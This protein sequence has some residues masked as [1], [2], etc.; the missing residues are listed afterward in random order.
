MTDH[1][2]LSRRLAIA[3]GW[4]D[5]AV[6]TAQNGSVYVWTPECGRVFDYRD[7]AVIWP[8]AERYDCFPCG[9]GGGVWAASTGIKVYFG[10]TAAEAVARA[11]IGS[12][13]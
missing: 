5:W 1:A 7:P 8:I 9:N 13:G 6:T 4:Q 12:K 10:D 3:I 2:D 11:V